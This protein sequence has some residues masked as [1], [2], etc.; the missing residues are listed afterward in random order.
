MTPPKHVLKSIKVGERE[1]EW[2]SYSSAYAET[3]DGVTIMDGMHID[4]ICRSTN[5]GDVKL[6]TL[7][8][9]AICFFGNP[10][11]YDEKIK[12]PQKISGVTIVI[13]TT[14]RFGVNAPPSP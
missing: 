5:I 1:I 11:R 13:D 2:F 12:L 9:V 3:P 8:T 6:L 14:C 7:N 4:T 10:M